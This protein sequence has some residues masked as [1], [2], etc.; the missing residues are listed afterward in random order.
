MTGNTLLIIA[1]VMAFLSAVIGLSIDK[2]SSLSEYK[3]TLLTSAAL[4][5]L[6][7]GIF[8]LVGQN[9]SNEETKKES[10]VLYKNYVSDLKEAFGVVSHRTLD[11]YLMEKAPGSYSQNETM[12]LISK[13]INKWVEDSL[14]K[15]EKLINE[16]VKV[17]YDPTLLWDENDSSTVGCWHVGN[18]KFKRNETRKGLNVI[19]YWDA[20]FWNTS[21]PW[22]HKYVHVIVDD[23]TQLKQ[24]S[25][26]T[27]NLSEKSRDLAYKYTKWYESIRPFQTTHQSYSHIILIVMDGRD[28]MYD[29]SALYE[30]LRLWVGYERGGRIN[31]Q[32]EIIVYDKKDLNSIQQVFE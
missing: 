5:A 11:E 10:D 17:E 18:I 2:F 29:G 23:G 30:E 9:K 14:V 8:T 26:T 1:M 13:A 16:N 22:D 25:F 15:E 28:P 19:S 31:G 20:Y 4:L 6:L 24:G 27:S 21:L 3:T 32:P 7:S 12:K